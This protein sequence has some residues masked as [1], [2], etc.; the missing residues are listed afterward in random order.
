MRK[1][2]KVVWVHNGTL[3]AFLFL[4]VVQLWTRIWTEKMAWFGLN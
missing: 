2:T 1:T 4:Y 3:I